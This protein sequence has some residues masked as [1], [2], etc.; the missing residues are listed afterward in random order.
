VTH[1]NEDLKPKY[2]ASFCDHDLPSRVLS[3][4]M[5]YDQI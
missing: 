3:T 5:Q 1:E 4:L 2:V